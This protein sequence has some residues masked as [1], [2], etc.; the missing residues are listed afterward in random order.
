MKSEV[1]IVASIKDG[2]GLSLSASSLALSKI[3]ELE[4]SSLPNKTLLINAINTALSTIVTKDANNE[5][6]YSN[7]SAP[8]VVAFN[9]SLGDA[10]T[11][12]E[13][14]KKSKIQGLHQ[15]QISISG[16]LQQAEGKIGGLEAFKAKQEAVN[17]GNQSSLGALSADMTIV[18]KKI[19]DNA[20]QYHYGN[21]IPTS[22]N[23]PA[24][25]WNSLDKCLEHEGD[26]YTIKVDAQSPQ[27]AQ[28]LNMF[29]YKFHR[30]VKGDPESPA[31]FGWHE[32][33][34]GQFSNLSVSVAT[35]TLKVEEND[36][37]DHF[38]QKV[39]ESAAHIV[40]KVK[41][42]TA[43]LAA[44]K[45]KADQSFK[46]EV[47]PQ[48]NPVTGKWKNANGSDSDQYAAADKIPAFNTAVSGANTA[49]ASAAEKASLANTA[50]SNANSKAT[51]AQQKADAANAAAVSANEKA[52]LANTAAANANS[53]ATLA[54]QKA[55]A[56]GSAAVEALNAK[57]IVLNAKDAGEFS[58]VRLFVDRVGDFRNGKVVNGI[59][60]K[61]ALT[62]RWF[63]GGVEKQIQGSGKTIKWYKKN[64]SGADT[65]KKTVTA[66]G[67]MDVRL[68]LS[69]GEMGTYY[70]DLNV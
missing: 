20:I 24:S 56:A 39:T 12:L 48:I 41:E 61:V 15:T 29:Q 17:V 5:I 65:L 22:S 68:L 69:D 57:T 34:G 16:K 28:G 46:E 23:E 42:P 63:L 9:A 18:K 13:A 67:S 19:I 51:L 37:A 14:D 26:I 38:K 50:A 27:S 62:P 33:G 70:F 32:I 47:T 10:S 31:D 36:S 7:Q 49:A 8:E 45:L 25:L 58:N 53:K 54:Q 2:A 60:G 3:K 11:A 52:S 4:A 64:T 30:T 40:E 21:A 66:T 44:S 1:L 55:D 59:G 35:L 43:T 6:D